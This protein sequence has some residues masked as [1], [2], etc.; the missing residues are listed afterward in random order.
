M[1]SREQI[2]YLMECR[3]HPIAQA[4]EYWIDSSERFAG[5]V[6]RYRDKIRKKCI[7]AKTFEDLEDIRVELEI[8]YLLLL[9]QRFEVE[10]EKFIHKEIR[11]PDFT[12]IFENCIEFNIEVKRIREPDLGH[13]FNRWKKEV[14]QFFETNRI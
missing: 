4:F 8:P 12:V 5:F 3:D 10:Y 2:I 9:D 1:N 11:S 13:R 7:T 6:R 14:V